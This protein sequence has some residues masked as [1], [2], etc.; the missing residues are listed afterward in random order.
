MPPDSFAV[1]YAHAKA[2]ITREFLHY[3]QTANCGRP[4]VLM[5]FS[6][7]AMLA[8][9][10]IKE[11]PD[12]V[13]ARCKAVYMMGYRL[14]AEDL[15]HERVLPA[16]DSIHGNVISFN[17]VM[18]TDATWDFV[19]KGAT[20][21]INPLNWRT[22]DMPATMVF[23]GD[24]A[25]VV[26]DTLTHQ[27]LVSGLDEEKYIFPL[28]APGNLHHWDLLFYADAIHRNILLRTGE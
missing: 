3:I 24:T 25:L 18:R 26:V 6:Q 14:S 28:S 5:G 23:E 27:L 10:L 22:D 2:D 1:A 15:A 16:T 7:G 9:D 13:Y 4:F 8:L 19:A 17:S 20:T 11:M 21:C 12:S